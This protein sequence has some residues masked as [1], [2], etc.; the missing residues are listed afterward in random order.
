MVVKD[1]QAAEASSFATP[2]AELNGELLFRAETAEFGDE[3]WKT[4]GTAE[5]TVQVKDIFPGTFGSW[6]TGIYSHDGL[7]Y[8]TAVNSDVNAGVW[9]TDGTEEGT[10][11]LIEDDSGYLLD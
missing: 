8:F 1:I 5:G 7:F 3:L 6:P 4:D 9:R 10:F 2:F 11:M